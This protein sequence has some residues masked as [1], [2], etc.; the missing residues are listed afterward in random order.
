M[1][2][3]QL[4]RKLGQKILIGNDIVI[5][6]TKTY[7]NRVKFLIE[8]PADVAVDREEVRDRKIANPGGPRC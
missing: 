7:A 8:A 1:A 3:L 2:G 4:E 5:T 6:V